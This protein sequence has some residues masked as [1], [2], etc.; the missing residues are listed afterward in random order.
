MNEKNFGSQGVDSQGLGSRIGNILT[1][2]PQFCLPWLD[3]IRHIFEPEKLKMT[4]LS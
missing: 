2:L 4:I 1:G 3:L